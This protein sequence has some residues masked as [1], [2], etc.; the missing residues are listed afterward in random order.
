[1]RAGANLAIFIFAVILGGVAAFLAR[2]W[3]QTRSARTD[4]QKTV[5]ILVANGALAFG[6]PI[7]AND[8]RETDRPAQSRPDGAFPNFADL[9]KN[10]RRITISPVVRDE[11]IIASKVSAPDQRASR[12]TVIEK[13]RRAVWAAREGWRWG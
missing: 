11:R 1:M 2:S 8:V 12:S 9:V 4:T 13:D 10:G 6:A 5:P 3:L 7:G